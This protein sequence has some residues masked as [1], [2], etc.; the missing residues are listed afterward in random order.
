MGDRLRPPGLWVEIGIRWYLSMSAAESQETPVPQRFERTERSGV[1]LTKPPFFS[2]HMQ[3]GRTL[4][5][6]RAARQ[7]GG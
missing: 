4:Y 1:T 3:E 6:Q 7:H 5:V 2:T